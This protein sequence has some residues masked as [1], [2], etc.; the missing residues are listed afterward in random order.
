MLLLESAP[1]NFRQGSRPSKS[2][3]WI[4]SHHF[5]S[6]FCKEEQK[7]SFWSYS[8]LWVIDEFRKRGV[9]D[10]VSSPSY[11]F[12]QLYPLLAFLDELILKFCIFWSTSIASPFLLSAQLGKPFDGV[13]DRICELTNL[14][15]TISTIVRW[16]YIRMTL[17]VEAGFSCDICLKIHFLSMV[18]DR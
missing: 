8:L 4:L 5:L 1:L 7:G 18:M 10:G 9:F 3:S 6:V 16:S 12:L 14:N 2:K 15:E 17:G 13:R 11:K